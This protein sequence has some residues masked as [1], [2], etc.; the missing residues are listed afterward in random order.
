MQ[1]AIGCGHDACCTWAGSSVAS[2]TLYTSNGW[3]V[4]GGVELWNGSG[5]V[6][7]SGRDKFLLPT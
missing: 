3:A 4:L 5:V 7:W 2:L 1:A 6:G